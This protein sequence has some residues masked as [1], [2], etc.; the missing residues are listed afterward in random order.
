MSVIRINGSK[1]VGG[2]IGTK[3]SQNNTEYSKMMFPICQN[4][5]GFPFGELKWIKFLIRSCQEENIT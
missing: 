3:H 4:I 2:T 1:A 5:C